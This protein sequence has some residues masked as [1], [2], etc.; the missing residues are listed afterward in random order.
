MVKLSPSALKL[1][2]ECPRCFWLDHNKKLKRPAGIFPSLPSGM[3]KIL[4]AH[5]DAF[6]DKGALPPELREVTG[7]TLFNDVETLKV[8]TN[9]FKG[10]SWTDPQGHV[11]KG[12]MD[13]VLKKGNKL[14]VLDFKT[15][16]YPLKEDTAEFYQDQLDVYNF[17]LRKNGH[18]TEDYAYLLF[19]HPE[20]V[21]ATGHVRFHAELVKMNISIKNAEALFRSALAVLHDK[22]PKPADDCA[23]CAWQHATP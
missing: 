13:Y 5:F 8:W 15:R 18:A 19:Y 11:L 20:E 23:F 7:I 12:A 21:D 3:D 6:R 16:G 14:I 17:L 10:I 22:M 4:K 2:R 1:F 9:N